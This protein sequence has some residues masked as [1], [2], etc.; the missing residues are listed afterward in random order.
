MKLLNKIQL[1]TN[2]KTQFTV[3]VSHTP[4]AKAVPSRL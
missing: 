4:D 1:T 2:Y 3:S